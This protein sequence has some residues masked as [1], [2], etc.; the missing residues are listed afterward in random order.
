MLYNMNQ[1]YESEDENIDNKTKIIRNTQK[2]MPPSKLALKPFHDAFRLILR[3][4]SVYARCSPDN[5]TQLVQS[6]QKEGFQVLMCGDGANDCGALKVADVG[7]SLSQEEAS[8]AAPFTSTNPDIS[9]IIDVL[10]EG[11]CALV[12]S[13]EIFKY[14]IA[15]S[16]TEYVAMTLMMFR[17]TFLFDF[18]S[19]AI[20]IFITLPLCIFL[21]MT[22][23]YETFNYH[24]PISNLA[25]FP[26]IIS[27][28]PQVIINAFFQIGAVILMNI[29][30]FPEKEIYHKARECRANNRLN[31]P[32]NN[33]DN[34][35][36]V[37]IPCLD[38]SIIFYVAFCQFL[39]VGIV[40]I[41]SA[42][43]KKRIYTNIPLF[44]FLIVAVSYVF[45]LI[46]YND[47]FS[48][49]SIKVTFFPDDDFIR[50][51]NVTEKIRKD[52][53]KENRDIG[54]PFKYYIVMYCI[55]NFFVC[56]LF[57]KKVVAYFIK[58]LYKKQFL[59]NKAIIRMKEIE[60]NLDLINDVKNY[61]RENEK[62][63]RRFSQ[64]KK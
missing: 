5:K 39:F 14:M 54:I 2:E 36:N 33:S 9:C 20:D 30:F 42:P 57:E 4:C 45:Y 51:Y 62:Y 12:T 44:L 3:H 48:K 35:D 47:P 16:L 37:K 17:N 11:K 31:N 41:T 60:P 19:I 10:N 58:I 21:P 7:V 34:D 15:F 52:Y 38:N 1:K 40:L 18:E 24:R 49:D 64:K 27:L 50:H 13:V 46:I 23:A 32:T 55:I 25:S 53:E 59:K 63:K 8:I 61:V 22:Q 26:I 43:F 28:F 6:L 56:Y 29:F